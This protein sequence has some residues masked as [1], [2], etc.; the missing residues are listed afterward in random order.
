MIVEFLDVRVDG[1]APYRGIWYRNDP[2]I[3]YYSGPQATFPSNIRPM[4]IFSATA[5]KTFFT[6]GGVGGR[7]FVGYF[8][9][10][11]G[12]L[13]APVDVGGYNDGDAHKNGSILIDASG[14]IYVFFGGHGVI[15]S[16]RRSAA[17]YDI[18]SW[19]TQGA[20]PVDGSPTYPQPWQIKSGEILCV[21]R[22]DAAHLSF[23]KSTDGAG[24]W[25]TQQ[26][27]VQVANPSTQGVYFITVAGVGSFPRPLHAIWNLWDNTQVRKNFWYA[28]S[29]DG[30]GTW[31]KSDGTA[32][33]TPMPPTDGELILDSGSQQVNTCDLVLDSTGLVRALV[34]Q[35]S[36]TNFVWKLIRQNGA[37]SWSTFTLPPAADNQ[38]DIG[39]LVLVGDDDWRAYLP[40]NPNIHNQ[41]G[42]EIQEWK[43]TDR[44]ATWSML[45]DVTSGSIYLHNNV[46]GVLGSQPDFRAFWSYG[47]PD[48][49]G[50]GTPQTT[51]VKLFMSGDSFVRQ[52]A[53]M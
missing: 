46:K 22:G 33:A 20:I 13:S 35:G 29:L 25:S 40:S 18:S 3:D 7:I 9:H 48:V 6:F 34:L 38:F 41:D 26:N 17:P 45:R 47:D 44:G 15:L 49:A 14:Y 4:A 50:A 19:V 16:C 11:T 1:W 39:A 8:D 31:Q 51:D 37:G 28:R 5:N 10:S 36:G 30:G 42:G 43:S 24:T 53:T 23:R 2:T 21:L 12:S 52:M 32:L 27:V